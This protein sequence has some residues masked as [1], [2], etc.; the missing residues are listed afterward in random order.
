MLV[1]DAI[2]IVVLKI[3]NGFV[4]NSYAIRTDL[5]VIADH[6]HLFRDVKQEKALDAQ[7]ARLVDD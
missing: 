5:L 7:L 6:N 1:G 3:G 4:G 2:K